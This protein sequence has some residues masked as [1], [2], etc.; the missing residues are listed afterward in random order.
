MTQTCTSPNVNQELKKPRRF[1]LN[2]DEET[3][4]TRELI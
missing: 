1:S 2:I 3:E 4:K